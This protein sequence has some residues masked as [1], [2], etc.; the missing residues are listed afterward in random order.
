MTVYLK[1]DLQEIVYDIQNKTYLTGKS[2]KDGKNHELVANMQANDD[3]ENANQ[4]LRSVAMAYGNLKTR[5]A[6]YLDQEFTAADNALPTLESQLNLALE[7]PSNFNLSTIDTLA[8][9]AHQYIVSMAVKDWFT[10]THKVDASDYAALG[11]ASLS[12]IAEAL[13]K[14]R[15]PVRRASISSTANS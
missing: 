5:L 4:V 2:R 9:A 6:E 13:N 15:R 1:L 8:A 12:I 11:E 7:M 14:R 10:I 3:E